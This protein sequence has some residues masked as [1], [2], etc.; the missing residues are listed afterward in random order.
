[1][2]EICAPPGWAKRAV[3]SCEPGASV[4]LLL[5]TLETALRAELA[6]LFRHVDFGVRDDGSNIIVTWVGG[7][8]ANEVGAGLSFE[9]ISESGDVLLLQV[10]SFESPDWP[11]P[12]DMLNVV[13]KR[14]AS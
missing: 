11:A 6:A 13:L 9:C 10:M 2:N 8:V 3:A 7:P 12:I 14:T 1:V 5:A 4:E